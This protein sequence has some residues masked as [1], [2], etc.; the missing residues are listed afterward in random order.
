MMGWMEHWEHVRIMKKGTLEPNFL[1]LNPGSDI[2]S[3]ALSKWL[4][5]YYVFVF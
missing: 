3:V 5:V 2:P 1:V 4:S